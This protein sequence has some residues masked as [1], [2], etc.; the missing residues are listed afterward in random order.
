MV[1]EQPEVD[2]IEADRQR[3]AQPAHAG[4]DFMRMFGRR[5]PLSERIVQPAPRPPHVEA[6]IGQWDVVH[7]RQRAYCA[8]PSISAASRSASSADLTAASRR[9]EEPTSEL[10]YLMRTSYA[11]LPL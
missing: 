7:S 11:V 9:S 6:V 3:H 10:Q 8:S 5:R 2:V 4:R 1:V